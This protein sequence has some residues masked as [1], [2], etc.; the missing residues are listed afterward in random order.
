MKKQKER[1]ILSEPWGAAS[2]FVNRALDTE[3]TYIASWS[4]KQIRFL[5]QVNSLISLTEKYLSIDIMWLKD[6]VEEYMKL[7][8]FSD[9]WIIKQAKDVAR[10][11][12]ARML[13]N[14]ARWKKIFLGEEE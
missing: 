7:S 8:K 1:E 13:L 10:G 3:E 14:I 5:A 9:G 4:P 2:I 12:S 6:L 11:S